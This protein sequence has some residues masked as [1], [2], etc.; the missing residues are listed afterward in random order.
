MRD[1]DDRRALLVELLEELHDFPPLIGM[2][3]PGGLVRQDHRRVRD[4][5]ARH[6]LELLLATG[7]LRGI[8]ILLRDDATRSA[9]DA[10]VRLNNM[11]LLIRS[12]GR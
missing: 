7:Q 5:G 9:N 4:D 11:G 2:Q 1:L 8:P 12:S 10:D 6:A 3:V